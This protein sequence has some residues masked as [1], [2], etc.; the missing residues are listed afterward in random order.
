MIV[1]HHGLERRAL[2]RVGERPPRACTRTC[3]RADAAEAEQVLAPALAGLARRRRRGRTDR[4]R[5]RET[6]R[7]DAAPASWQSPRLGL[8]RQQL[9]R[10]RPASC[11]GS[12][13]GAPARAAARRSRVRHAL[14]LNRDAATATRPAPPACRRRGCPAPLDAAGRDRRRTTGD[15]RCG[16]ARRSAPTSG[17]R[18]SARPARDTA[19]APSSPA[20]TAS[21]NLDRTWR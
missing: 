7:R 3:R 14:G 4:L 13:A 15:R 21:R 1:G 17:R 2:F 5:D 9:E 6:D 10:R 19:P 12:P 18:R 11:A 16:A 20:S 8:D